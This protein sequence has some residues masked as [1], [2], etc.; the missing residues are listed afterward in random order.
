MSNLAMNLDVDLGVCFEAKNDTIVDFNAA[1]GRARDVE[2]KQDDM[3]VE[4]GLDL[5][6]S[7]KKTINTFF[8]ASGLP[9]LTIEQELALALGRLHRLADPTAEQILE[10]LKLF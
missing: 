1:T 5:L 2:I 4:Y 10:V 7:D 8:Q 3:P 6:T 9:P